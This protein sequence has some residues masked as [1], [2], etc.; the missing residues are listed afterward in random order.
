MKKSDLYVTINYAHRIP[1][2]GIDGPV[3]QPIRL[4]L[5]MVAHLVKC[6][7][8]VFEHDPSN[9]SSKVA[10]TVQNLDDDKFLPV[11][12]T[13]PKFA[14]AIPVVEKTSETVDTDPDDVSADDDTESE[15]DGVFDFMDKKYA[16]MSKN[17]IKKA[18][19]A[20]A[21]TRAATINR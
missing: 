4:P 15:D 1:T 14:V 6:G 5:D 21:A 13:A 2:L 9:L 20:E 19:K 17:Q 3:L 12:P 11:I 10:L 16:G 8:P 7:F 18:R